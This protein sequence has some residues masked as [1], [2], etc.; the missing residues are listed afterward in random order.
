MSDTPSDDA[1]LVQEADVKL[2]DKVGG[3]G[4]LGKLFSA[5]R[6]QK[7]Q[8]VIEDFKLNFF[9]EMNAHLNVLRHACDGP[10]ID[11][12]AV[13]ATAK[14]LK[15]QAETLGFDLLY[16]LS[17]ALYQYVAEHKQPLTP[18]QELVVQKHAEATIVTIERQE[19]G[20]GGVTEAELLQSLA[21]LRQ[22][23]S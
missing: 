13:K 15:S 7:G 23:F 5:D 16:A 17:S 14:A 2:R 10:P 11:V 22:K 3:A 8:R 1:I 18:Q 12:D 20:K 4:A 6:I 21:I 9:G 19:R